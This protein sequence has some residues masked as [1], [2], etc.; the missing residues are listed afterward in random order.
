MRGSGL[1]LRKRDPGRQRRVRVPCP[2]QDTRN[3]RA[4]AS[5]TRS[6]G[7]AARAEVSGNKG[8]LKAGWEPAPGPAVTG[9]SLGRHLVVPAAVTSPW[10]TRGR[11]SLGERAFLAAPSSGMEPGST[12]CLS[13]LPQGWS[14]SPSSRLSSVPWGRSQSSVS[15]LS[16]APSGMEPALHILPVSTSLRMSGCGWG[17]ASR[18]SP[19]SFRMELELLI[20]SPD[21][22]SQPSLCQGG[23]RSSGKFSALPPSLTQIQ[24]PVGSPPW[25]SPQT[26]SAGFQLSRSPNW[27]GQPVPGVVTDRHSER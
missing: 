11:P 22:F 20:P 9:L 5:G 26:S 4:N 21:Q 23:V 8:E 17:P 13:R 12:P 18:L 14:W 16:P 27:P 15:C 6:K 19:G 2:F 7:K 10:L 1:S 24:V 25:S 3:A